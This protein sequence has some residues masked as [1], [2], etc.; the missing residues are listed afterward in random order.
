MSGQAARLEADLRVRLDADLRVWL[1]S[2]AERRG[3]NKS[4][5]C[6]RI[7]AF[8]RRWSEV[9]LLWRLMRALLRD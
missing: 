7:L 6:R 4:R 9:G 1:E 2:E 8:Y 5:E 3:T